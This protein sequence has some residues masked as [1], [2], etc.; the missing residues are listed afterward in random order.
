[1]ASHLAGDSVWLSS[2]DKISSTRVPP[3][4]MPSLTS[5]TGAPRL[6]SGVTPST[7]ELATWNSSKAARSAG[8]A[9]ISSERQEVDSTMLASIA[10][11]I[12]ANVSKRDRAS[13]NAF[14]LILPS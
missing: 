10:F 5:R 3:G 14:A 12:A 13:N 7:R 2:Q 11:T 8:R 9:M 1:M 4:N 6:L